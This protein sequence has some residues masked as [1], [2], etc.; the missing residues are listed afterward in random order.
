MGRVEK[1]LQLLHGRPLIEHVTD[2]LRPQVGRLLI[3]ANREQGAYAPMA[4]AVIPDAA[5]YEGVGPLGGVL[6][7]RPAIQSPMIFVCPGDAPR[8]DRSLVMRLYAAMA[9]TACDAVIPHDGTQPQYLFLLL[10]LSAVARLPAYLAQ[11]RRSVQGFLEQL[12]TTTIEAS[13]IADSFLNINTQEELSAANRT[14]YT[15]E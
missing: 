10:R 5:G 3:S 6:A 4:D 7:A 15:M 9:S 8:I 14:P 2:R 13:D 1:P 11:Q 12:S